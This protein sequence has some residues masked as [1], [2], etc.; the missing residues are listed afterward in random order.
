MINGPQMDFFFFFFLS[1]SLT[2]T[3]K[4]VL[5]VYFVFFFILKWPEFWNVDHRCWACH[6]WLIGG[7]LTYGLVQ[8]GFGL[9]IRQPVENICQIKIWRL[10]WCHWVSW[11]CINPF[12]TSISTPSRSKP[13]SFPSTPNQRKGG[14][15]SSSH[16]KKKPV[17]RS[18]WRRN[19]TTSRAAGYVHFHL[20]SVGWLMVPWKFLI[21]CDAVPV[22]LCRTLQCDS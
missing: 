15:S 7:D 14:V 20:G 13:L 5:N 2:R 3:D 1:N 21:H 4:I 16:T 12:N 17:S 10:S 9:P 11:M 19:T 22:T 8:T 18:V 6:C